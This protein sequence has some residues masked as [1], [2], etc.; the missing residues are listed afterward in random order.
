MALLKILIGAHGRVPRWVFWAT[1]ILFWIGVVALVTTE[2][3]W[4]AFIVWYAVSL[5]VQLVVWACRARDLGKR[6][7]FGLTPLIPLAGL[8]FFLWLGFGGT[9]SELSQSDQLAD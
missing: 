8:L 9:N 2:A 7:I 6:G 5:W 1:L 4:Y 3:P